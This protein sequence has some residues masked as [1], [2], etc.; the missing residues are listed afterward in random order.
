MRW[1]Y[2]YR[3]YKL[4]GRLGINISVNTFKGGLYIVHADL[5]RINNKA[6]IGE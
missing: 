1:Y 2:A 3:H 4:G 6:R 5:I